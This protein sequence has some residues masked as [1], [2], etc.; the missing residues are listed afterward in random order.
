MI[1]TFKR[2]VPLEY[3]LFSQKEIFKI[4]D[5]RR[6]F[7]M[8][9]HKRAVEAANRTKKAAPAGPGRGGASSSSAPVRRGPPSDAADRQN[10][11][12]LVTF[13]RDKS[14]LPVVCFTLSKRRC[15]SNAHGLSAMDL[16]ST[17]EKSEIRL[18][19]QTSLQRLKGAIQ[20]V[21]LFC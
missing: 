6:E 12:S 4:V 2:P 21:F 19:L 11:I 17:T 18:F 5:A 15:E 14:L 20:I 10:W 1:S 8:D 13:L 16:T 7:L 3:F 9:G